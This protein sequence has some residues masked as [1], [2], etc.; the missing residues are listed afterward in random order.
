MVADLVCAFLFL[1]S[2]YFFIPFDFKQHCCSS[3]TQFTRDSM[4]LRSCKIFGIQN[5]LV[6]KSFFRSLIVYNLQ[7]FNVFTSRF[8]C[9]SIAHEWHCFHYCRFC[10]LC[11][12]SFLC[13]L[14]FVHI[15]L[16]KNK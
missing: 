2:I 13:V 6:R 15:K 11:N 7:N 10:M 3:Y 4:C 8:S 5:Q 12:S 1:S 16:Q 14:N 9:C